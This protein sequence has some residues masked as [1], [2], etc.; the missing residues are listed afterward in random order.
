MK[1]CINV[2]IGCFEKPRNF[3]VL[4]EKCIFAKLQKS[5]NRLSQLLPIWASER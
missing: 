5:G 3:V 4:E 1:K 2:K